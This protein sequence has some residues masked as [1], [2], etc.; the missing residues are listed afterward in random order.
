MLLIHDLNRQKK[1]SWIAWPT[2]NQ[3]EVK[4]TSNNLRRQSI[5]L[6]V[7]EVPEMKTHNP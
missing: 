6:T 5:T 1:G 7:P 3:T 2:S 4:K